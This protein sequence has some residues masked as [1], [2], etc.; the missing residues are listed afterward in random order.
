MFPS[1]VKARMGGETVDA[2]LVLKAHVMPGM[3]G[4]VIACAPQFITEFDGAA[5][6]V[7]DPV[8]KKWGGTMVMP[9]C[10]KMALS[11]NQGGM[12]VLGCDPA[13]CEGGQVSVMPAIEQVCAELIRRE[14]AGAGRT[15][16]EIVAA[17]AGLL[18][19]QP[20]RKKEA[21]NAAKL[22]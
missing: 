20:V 19:D 22:G 1:L 17:V 6:L 7:L 9:H 8:S 5:L 16:K 15:V 10:A 21:P 14:A 13:L 18:K 11:I 3:K 12:M 2:N 4:K